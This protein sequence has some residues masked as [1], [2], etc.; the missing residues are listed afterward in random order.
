MFSYISKYIKYIIVDT[1]SF[2]ESKNTK[3][4]LNTIITKS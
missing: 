2:N 4:E 1:K 3:K